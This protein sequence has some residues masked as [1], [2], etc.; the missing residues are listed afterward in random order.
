MARSFLPFQA[1]TK[2]V[3]VE[4]VRPVR[5]E[6][7]SEIGVSRVGVCRFDAWG[8]Y[9]FSVFLGGCWDFEGV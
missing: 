7:S 3:E 6:V 4:A 8:I 9:G 2:S 5:G 1:S